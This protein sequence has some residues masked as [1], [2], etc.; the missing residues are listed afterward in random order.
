MTQMF[1]KLCIP[2]GPTPVRPAS[3]FSDMPITSTISSSYI[4]QECACESL[5][6]YSKTNEATA[7]IIKFVEADVSF[8]GP[9]AD[10]N[11]QIKLCQSE[12][13]ITSLP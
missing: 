13:C 11:I 12:K 8:T 5:P 1:V 2:S 9:I 6:K 7:W 10:L 4:K 3:L